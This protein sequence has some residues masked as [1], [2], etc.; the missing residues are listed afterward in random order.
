M[1]KATF[2]A[3]ALVVAGVLVQAQGIGPVHALMAGTSGWSRQCKACMD[4]CDADFPRGGGPLITCRKLCKSGSSPAC[5][6]KLLM[7]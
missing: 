5:K 6:S 1:R 4:K 7:Q 2:A 3:A